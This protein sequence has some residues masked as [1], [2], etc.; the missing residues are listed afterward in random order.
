M[1]PNIHPASAPLEWVKSSFSGNNGNCV[2]AAVLPG[3]GR[4]LRDSKNPSGPILTFSADEFAAFIAGA[5]AGEF[6][7]A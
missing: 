7:Q 4:A 1:K 3:G 2:E 6:D 5:V